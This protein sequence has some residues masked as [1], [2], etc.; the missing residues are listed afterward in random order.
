MQIFLEE[1]AHREE[2][3]IEAV[4]YQ[5]PESHHTSPVKQSLMLPVKEYNEK[6]GPMGGQKV[7]EDDENESRN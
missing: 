7:R 3:V 5:N 4:D 6:D 2:D 1:T